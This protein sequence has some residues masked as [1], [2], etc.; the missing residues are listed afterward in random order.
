MPLQGTPDDENESGLTRGFSV[1]RPARV[2]LDH[3]DSNPTTL[4]VKGNKVAVFNKDRDLVYSGSTRLL[5]NAVKAACAA[6]TGH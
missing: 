6:I 1:R 5:G 2:R 4:F 3:E